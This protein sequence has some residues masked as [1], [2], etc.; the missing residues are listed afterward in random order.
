MPQ[1]ILLSDFVPANL[2]LTLTKLSVVRAGR[3][4][5]KISLTQRSWARCSGTSA[6]L[7]LIYRNLTLASIMVPKEVMNQKKCEN[8]LIRLTSTTVFGKWC[9][10]KFGYFGSGGQIT[11]VEQYRPNFI[12]QGN[13]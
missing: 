3:Y 10:M 2:T 12:V 13:G 5:N 8:L 11:C 7:I 6:S 4:W 1:N 9:P